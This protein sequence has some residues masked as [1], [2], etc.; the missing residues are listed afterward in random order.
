MSV[1]AKVP[2]N[3]IPAS[4]DGPLVTPCAGDGLPRITLRQAP[5]D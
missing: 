2:G 3:R 1:N 5:I 4:L